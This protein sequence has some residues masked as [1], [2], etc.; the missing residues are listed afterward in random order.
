M[1]IGARSH[2]IS[3]SVTSADA[4]TALCES[5]TDSPLAP[6]PRCGPDNPRAQTSAMHPEQGRRWQAGSGTKNS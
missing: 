2:S 5:A 3:I 4:A 1:S 6:L